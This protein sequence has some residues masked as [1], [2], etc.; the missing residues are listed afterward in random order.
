MDADSYA[1][2]RAIAD[3]E[4]TASQKLVGF[5]LALHFNR[6]TQESRIRR[7]TICREAGLGMTAMKE[8]LYV[9]THSGVFERR[10]TG[11]ASAYGVGNRV[12]IW[13]GRNA[14][15]QTGRN[16]THQEETFEAIC[17]AKYKAELQREQQEKQHS[18][19]S[20]RRCRR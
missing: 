9:L 18:Y 16:P 1:I 17:E 15:H 10:R 8:A 12:E 5:V 3:M 19:P 4:L 6:Q 2:M 20:P 11:R 14:T 7:E 13:M